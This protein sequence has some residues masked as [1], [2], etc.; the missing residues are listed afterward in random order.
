VESKYLAAC[1][2]QSHDN[3]QFTNIYLKVVY[4]NDTEECYEHKVKALELHPRLFKAVL[5]M[6]SS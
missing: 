1:A 5:S 6:S 3:L 2:V 4:V